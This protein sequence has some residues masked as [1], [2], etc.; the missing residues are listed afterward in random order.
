[1]FA[2]WPYTFAQVWKDRFLLLSRQLIAD[3]DCDAAVT[4]DKDVV[5]ASSDS[6][7]DL[8]GQLPGN[9]LLMH[10]WGRNYCHESEIAADAA[11][12]AAAAAAA[13]AFWLGSSAYH[14]KDCDQPYL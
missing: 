10:R 4:L 2:A 1:M 8:P 13:A 11:A 6:C 9:G 14:S 3:S 12:D 7:C 5:S